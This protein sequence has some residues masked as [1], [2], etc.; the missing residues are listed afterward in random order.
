M[1]KKTENL[2]KLISLGNISEAEIE[3]LKLKQN[4]SKIMNIFLYMEL[5]LRKKIL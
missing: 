3:I 4:D 2:Y 5:F 1:L